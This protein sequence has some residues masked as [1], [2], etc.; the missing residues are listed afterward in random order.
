MDDINSRK[1]DF[2]DHYGIS[3]AVGAAGVISG[4]NEDSIYLPSPYASSRLDAGS[5]V[6]GVTSNC[7]GQ[8]NM[9][10]G[11][12]ASAK[13]LLSSRNS[14]QSSNMY[15]IP[16]QRN[17]PAKSTVRGYYHIACLSDRK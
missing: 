5:I 1:S 14:L 3:G 13:H 10:D 11:R 6:G 4:H 9:R 2:V 12:S 7:V 17:H 16:Q 8:V 15:D